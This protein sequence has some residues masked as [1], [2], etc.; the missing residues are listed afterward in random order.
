MTRS[1][2]ETDGIGGAL[3]AVVLVGIAASVAAVALVGPRVALGVG[4]GAAA[5]AANLW[6]LTRVVRGFLSGANGLPW[7]VIALVKMTFLF[8]GL[9][10]LVKS[11]VAGVMPLVLGFGALPVGIV[12]SQMWAAPTVGEES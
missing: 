9:Y 5:A 3:R 7:G 10:L 11:G 6:V 1:T 8:G 2:G 12:L 4:I